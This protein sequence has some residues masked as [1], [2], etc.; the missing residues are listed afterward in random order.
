MVVY[1]VDWFFNNDWVIQWCA[2]LA[3][4][5]Q[6]GVYAAP[7]PT[8][9]QVR[10]DRTVGSLPLLPYS[11]MAASGFIWTVYGILKQEPKLW[12]CCSV[13]VALAAY[14]LYTFIPYAPK[15]SSTTLPG[16]VS[17]HLQFL[18]IIV[19]VTIYLVTWYSGTTTKADEILGVLGLVL[20]ISLFA[21]PL[22]VVQHVVQTKCAKSIPLP[23]TL[24]TLVNC[25]LWTL[26]GLYEMDDPNVYIPNILGFT[27]AI[28]QASLKVLYGDGD[29]HL[30]DNNSHRNSG[31]GSSVQLLPLTSTTHG[32]DGGVGGQ[33]TRPSQR[34]R[35]Q[36]AN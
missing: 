30:L 26:T 14:Y 5:A 24:A 32:S 17:Q 35:E 12:S 34:H 22:S 8:I 16:T 23:F 1:A 18:S 29:H 13:G 19:L 25:G 15:Q 2:Q 21:S 36:Q 9:Q 33:G 3:P 20:S 11:S 6:I 10:R 27:C 31:H 28:V 4:Y 7:L